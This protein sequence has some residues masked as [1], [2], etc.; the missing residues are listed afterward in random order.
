VNLLDTDVL[1]HLQKKD[2]IG[3]SIAVAMAASPDA[4]FRITTVNACEMLDGAL[5]LIHDLR[6]N[7]RT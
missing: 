5:G 4:D 7:T 1:S 3:D 6:K 2:P